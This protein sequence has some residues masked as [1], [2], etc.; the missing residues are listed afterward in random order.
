MIYLTQRAI[1]FYSPFNSKTLIGTGSKIYIPYTQCLKVK[2]ESHLIIFKNALRITLRS[3]QQVLF[4]NFL[5]RDTC[6]C[7]VANQIKIAQ[8]LKAEPEPESL[9]KSE[10]LIHVPDDSQEGSISSSDDQPTT[11]EF[12]NLYDA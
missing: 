3:K 8:L 5:S 6:Y 12:N 4:Q 10:H 1:Y 2:K 9:K 11:P 7:M